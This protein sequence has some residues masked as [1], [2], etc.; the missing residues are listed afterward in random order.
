MLATATHDHKRGEDIRARLAAL[1]EI[2]AIWESEVRDWFGLNAPLRSSQI[3]PGDEY[4]L[5]QTLAACWPLDLRADQGPAMENFVR[6]IAEW[7]EKSL[8]EAKLQTSWS[9]PNA[10]FEKANSDF[11]RAILDPRRAPIFLDRLLRFVER[12]APAGVLNSLVQCVLRYTCP[13][14][15]D[16]Y[17]GTELWDF[18]L[19]DP[20]NRRPVDFVGRR[21]LLD[22][23]APPSALLP[24]W[25]NG[26]VKLAL[27]RQLL[28]LRVTAPDCLQNGDFCPLD[29]IGA[30]AAHVAA[31][32][33][34]ANGKSVLVTV[35]LLCAQG[36][37]ERNAPLP[38]PAFWGDCMLCPNADLRE[39]TWRSALD[40]QRSTIAAWDCA[41]L[42]AEFPAAVLVSEP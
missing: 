33:R 41:S 19:V 16:L 20:D 42:F 37:M 10:A 17:Q 32:S 29:V 28:T 30:R 1:S 13:G 6:R 4:Q 15:P 25:R 14:I 40:P 9:T 26:R 7:R 8:R 39:R 34:S 3:A 18:S 36:S 23:G 24:Q 2:P 5:Y 35:P 38:S 31:F 11:T 27:I 21:R 12:L 22:S